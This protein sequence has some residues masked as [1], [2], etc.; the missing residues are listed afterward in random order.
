ML[1]DPVFQTLFQT[2]W[3]LQAAM[4]VHYVCAFCMCILRMPRR[5]TLKV[6][7][8]APS[9]HPTYAPVQHAHINA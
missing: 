7:C 6:C 4:H 5:F 3:S 1:L 9:D 2:C 8:P